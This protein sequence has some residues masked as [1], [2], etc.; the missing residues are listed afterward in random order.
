M[1]VSGWGSIYLDFSDSDYPEWYANHGWP[2]DLFFKLKPDGSLYWTNEQGDS[3]YL[4]DT[5][6]VVAI[7]DQ[8]F[9]LGPSFVKAQN[10]SGFSIPATVATTPWMARMPWCS[11]ITRASCGWESRSKATSPSSRE[12]ASSPSPQ[13]GCS[14][15]RTRSLGWMAPC[16]CRELPQLPF[17]STARAAAAP[18]AA[19]S[20]VAAA[21][22]RSR[23]RPLSMRPRGFGWTMQTSRLP[24]RTSA[25]SASRGFTP[26]RR[27][28]WWW[29]AV[30]WVQRR[31]P[32]KGLL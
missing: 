16:W 29:M 14:L 26:R 17:S 24:I 7:W 5:E 8:R 13:P 32:R 4:L 18:G 19:S 11:T 23:M 20:S 1:T 2:R 30:W 9:I 31:A 6:Q 12:R 27:G 28:R 25:F 10:M 21:A 3:E 15:R 22:A